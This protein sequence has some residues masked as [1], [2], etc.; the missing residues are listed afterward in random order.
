MKREGFDAHNVGTWVKYGG[1]V[2]STYNASLC[3]SGLL[4]QDHRQ[5]AIKAYQFMLNN[6]QSAPYGFWEMF[7]AVDPNN[8]W[9]GKHPAT[10]SNW[11]CCPHQWGQAGATQALLDALAAEFYDGKILIGRGYLDEWCT[12]GKVTEINNFP[13][14]ANGRINLRIEF[15]DSQKVELTISGSK[16]TNDLWFNLPIFKHNLVSATA[17]K[18]DYEHGMLVLEP[19]EQKVTVTLKAAAPEANA[20]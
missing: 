17:G 7:Q 13:I 8:S 12:A 19:T 5:E 6:G 16:P 4:S 20:N 2:S 15:L 10:Q 9:S 14:S 11:Y 1:G 18:I 3:I